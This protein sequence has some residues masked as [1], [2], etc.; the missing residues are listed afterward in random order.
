M[1]RNP[2]EADMVGRKAIEPILE[3]T[4]AML[5]R[6][7]QLLSENQ[8]L[9]RQAAITA[10]VAYVGRKRKYVALGVEL[11]LLVAEE[12]EKEI[13]DA[14][15]KGLRQIMAID[16]KATTKSIVAWA[17]AN[18]TTER[19]QLAALFVKSAATDAR[20]AIEKSVVGVVAKF[21]NGQGKATNGV[22]P[23]KGKAPTSKGAAAKR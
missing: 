12:H 3:R 9:I 16:P 1:A 4:P 21:S 19:V 8:K 5:D 13:R 10:L 14:V 15:R 7:K 2:A 23:A 11:L 17:K 6:V 20:L 22:K 18:P